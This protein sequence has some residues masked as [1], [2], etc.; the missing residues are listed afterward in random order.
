MKSNKS[1]KKVYYDNQSDT[2]WFLI[3]D[4]A[5]EEYQE[6]APGIN[7]ELG[8]KGELMGIEVLNASKVLKPFFDRKQISS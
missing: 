1:N 6:I 4:G 2:L 7:V 8:K 5:E 3:K